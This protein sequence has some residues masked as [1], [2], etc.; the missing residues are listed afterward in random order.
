MHTRLIIDSQS[1]ISTLLFITITSVVVV[2]GIQIASFFRS[3]GVCFPRPAAR[4][5]ITATTTT[6]LR[7]QLIRFFF[8]YLFFLLSEQTVVIITLFSLYGRT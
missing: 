8:F 3:P 4:D 6:L 5:T 7:R 2:Y 1:S